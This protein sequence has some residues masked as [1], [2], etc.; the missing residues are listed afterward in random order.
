MTEAFLRKSSCF[1]PKQLLRDGR[2]VEWLLVAHDHQTIVIN[3]DDASNRIG[4]VQIQ[5]TTQPQ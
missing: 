2:R 1:E 4:Y 3:V 5:S